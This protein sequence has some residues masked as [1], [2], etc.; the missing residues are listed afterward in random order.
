MSD[1]AVVIGFK[2]ENEEYRS[3][4]LDTVD[5]VKVNGNSTITEQPLVSGD[6]VSD[7][8]YNNPKTMSV[9]GTLSMNDSKV[10][11]VDGEGSKL[12]NFQELFERIQKEGVKCDIVKISMK[13]EE[14]IRFL[15]RRNM[16]VQT[17]GWTERIN[18]LDYTLSFKEVLMAEAIALDVDTDDNYLPAI[19]EPNTLSFTDT[20]INW[21]YIDEN[22]NR[23]L[24]SNELIDK[25]TL[26][27]WSSLGIDMLKSILSAA[28]AVV[29]VTVLS[30]GV[31]AL[32]PLAVAAFAAY[33][34]F[35][36]IVNFFKRITMRNKYKVDRF[37]YSKNKKKNEAELKRY[38]EFIKGIHDEFEKTNSLFHVY[39]ISQNT[40][41]E[42]MINIG[43]NY[44]I[45]TFSQNNLDSKY[46]LKVQDMKETEVA[47]KNDI[48]SS[49]TSFDEL[50]NS[51]QLFIASNQS[52]VYLLYVPIMENEDSTEAQAEP[53]PN[54]LRNY[55]IFV[56]DMNVEKFQELIEKI[57][58]SKILRNYSV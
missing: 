35:K 12:A 17:H 1:F 23:I 22:I 46:T 2:F 29:L 19:T 10:T 15:H 9:S 44:Y 13:N 14:D 31:G 51:N 45:F 28:V 34:F 58:K 11:V 30:S 16:V 4:I 49:P 41:Q 42:C 26:N 18:S 57:I 7:H 20:L 38:G 21:D 36:G 25:M 54:D 55:M 32:F 33:M 24:L 39:R 47:A 48:T 50:N 5:D 56:S 43:D 6:I 52:N 27:A 53:N 8:M 3:V 40:P 37:K